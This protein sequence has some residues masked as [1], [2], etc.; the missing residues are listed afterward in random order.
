MGE[1]II[2]VSADSEDAYAVLP[3]YLP[4]LVMYRCGLTVLVSL[5]TTSSILPRPHAPPRFM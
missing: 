2:V 4:L 5:Q 1:I 3:S